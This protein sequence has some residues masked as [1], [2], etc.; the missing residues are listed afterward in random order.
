MSIIPPGNVLTMFKI[1]VPVIMFDIM[2]SIT[3]FQDL[4]PDS[5]QDMLLS[6]NLK[7]TQLID[8][9]YDSF[10]PILNLGTLFVLV[11][12]YILESILFVLIVWPAR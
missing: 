7:L 1:V 4:W 2:E 8:I 10:N 9:G 5:E 6:P 11:L 3:Y 12:L